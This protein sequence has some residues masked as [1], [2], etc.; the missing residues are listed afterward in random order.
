M[1]FF[2]CYATRFLHQVEW[3]LSP[4]TVL[5]PYNAILL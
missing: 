3:A 2:F 5:S 1:P 4:L